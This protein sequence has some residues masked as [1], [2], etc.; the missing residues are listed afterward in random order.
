METLAKLRAGQLSNVVRLDL[1]GCALSEFPAEIFALADSLEILNLSGNALTSL[2][3]DLHRLRRMRVLFC[4]DNLFTQVPACVGKCAEL[5]MIG[6]KANRIE[7]VSADALPPLLRWLIL[8]DNR[9]RQLPDELG[10]RAPRMQKLMLAGNRLQR[11]PTS[12]AK[13]ANLELIRIASNDL[14]E[15]PAFLLDMPSLAWIAYAGNPFDH[16]SGG[17][18]YASLD[19]VDKIAWSELELEPRALG[20]GASG[21][22]FQ[23]NLRRRAHGEHQAVAIKLYKGDMTSDGAPLA[24]M[25]A[26]IA[27]GRHANLIQVE[28]RIVDHPEARSGLVMHLIDKSYRNLADVPSLA[29]CSRDVYASETRLSA[30]VLVRL[31]RGVASVGAHLHARGII[32]GDLY[33]HN[34]LWNATDGHC[35][36]GDFGA[37]SFLQMP[38]QRD[39][40]DDEMR[41]RRRAL[42]RIEVRSF[43]ILLDELLQRVDSDMAEERRERLRALV[44]RCCQP[45]VQS[46][47]DFV[48]VEKALSDI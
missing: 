25:S 45:S 26:C 31:A 9:I 3:D 30:D 18:D 36:L 46:R 13:C 15:F 11:L 8:T 14:T 4:S 2:P 29:S 41:R 16:G 17:D 35:L 33:A 44:D 28:G 40:D 23:A 22:I 21:V 27:A 20:E 32:H 7:H 5:S 6:F 47:P 1:T 37:A 48:E 12:L 19:S 42:Q 38:M 39:D 10:E 43:G 24:E 34:I